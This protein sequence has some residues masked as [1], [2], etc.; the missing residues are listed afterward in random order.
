MVEPFDHAQHHFRLA[1]LP[2]AKVRKD[3]R[4]G[5]G[6]RAAGSV[7]AVQAWM[8]VP[9]RISGQCWGIGRK[10]SE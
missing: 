10:L 8:K 5:E 4:I 9:Y 6:R 1:G 2:H 3:R 7:P